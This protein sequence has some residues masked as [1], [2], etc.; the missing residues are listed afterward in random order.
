M[1]N[2]INL[3]SLLKEMVGHYQPQLPSASLIWWRA[4]IA[5]KLREKERI[6]RPLQV[7]RVT[8]AIACAVIL[9]TL[10]AHSW[11][12]LQALVLDNKWLLLPLFLLTGS[13][14]VA[15]FVSPW[16]KSDRFPFRWTSTPG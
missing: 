1:K 2:E 5:R 14:V 12:Q 15:L 11:G 4:Q 10:S 16:A 8:A 9:A 13:L 6:E 7:M 3:D